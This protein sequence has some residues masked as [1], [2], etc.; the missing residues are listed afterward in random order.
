MRTAKSGRRRTKGQE[1]GTQ[2]ESALN[3]CCRFVKNPGNNAACG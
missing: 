1:S 3:F 2:V